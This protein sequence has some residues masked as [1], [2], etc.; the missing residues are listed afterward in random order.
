MIYYSS[1]FF[2]FSHQYSA[3]MSYC[4]LCFP[5]K[6]KRKLFGLFLCEVILVLS[7][8]AHSRRSHWRIE[9]GRTGRQTLL[10]G[11]KNFWQPVKTVTRRL[12]KNR[13]IKKWPKQFPRQK[14]Q[15]IYIKDQSTSKFKIQVLEYSKYGNSS[16][17]NSTVILLW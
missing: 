10:C 4:H 8:C 16:N 3:P 13:L 12:G 6:C 17:T 7:C 14:S 15:S 5:C 2:P 11:K 9:R 1:M